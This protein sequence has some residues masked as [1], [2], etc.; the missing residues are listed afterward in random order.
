MKLIESEDLV[1]S[2][3]LWPKV[4]EYVGD[5]EQELIATEMKRR[6][7]IAL[8]GAL[9]A[10]V[11]GY[12]RA[13]R[14]QRTKQRSDYLNGYY[15]RNLVTRYGLVVGLRVP[16]R[17]QGGI[18]H[19]VFRRYQ[20]R[21]K[22]VDDWL[23][24]L[25]INGVS[26]RTVGQLMRELLGCAVSASTVSAINKTLDHEVRAF[27]RR[28]VSNDYVYLF[29]DGVTQKVMS[30]GRLI[31][32]LVLV[33]YGIKL[34][35]TRNIIDYRVVK[36]ETEH[37]WQVFLNDLYRRGLTGEYLRL[38]ITDGGKGLLAALELV[39][40]HVPWQRC[41]VHK[42]RNVAGYV[43]RK[44]QKECLAGVR[45]IYEAPHQR[46]A[47]QRFKEWRRVWQRRSPKAVHCLE[48]DLDGLLPFFTQ[49]PK[50]WRKIRTTNVIERTFRELRKRTKSIYFFT[51]EDSCQ[52]IIYAI[53]MNYNR[54][55][56]G[57]PL[58]TSKE[59]TH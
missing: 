27:H 31:K 33:A 8:E 53:F 54:K 13:S 4:K 55:M 57:K 38:I 41:W 59:F 1:K 45:R 47:V 10:E 3:R 16:R 51:N 17:R 32:K 2:N 23:R 6:L 28:P 48:K 25:F 26:T 19:Q 14:Y 18:R 40:P 36:G 21:Q 9:K 46:G 37:D 39:Y 50:L 12:T 24:E 5:P 58:W 22:A 30:Y 20:R 44:Q 35:G 7:R 52:R 29:L 42:M 49:D 34:D 15:L 56:E 11:L 43:S